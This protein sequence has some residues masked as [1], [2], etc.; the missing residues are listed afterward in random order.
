MSSRRSGRRAISLLVAATIVLTGWAGLGAS[1][2]AVAQPVVRATGTSIAVTATAGFQF[3][4]PEI[5]NVPLN[6]TIN[7]TFSDTDSGGLAHTFT[8]LNRSDWQI[9]SSADVAALMTDNGSLI[10]LNASYQ[11]TVQGNFHSPTAPGWYEFVCMASGH[12]QS[13][14]YGF[15]AFGEPV[16]TN[17]SLAS[18][19]PPAGLAVFIIVGTIVGLTVIALVLGFV[20]GRRHGDMHEMPPERLGYPEPPVAPPPATGP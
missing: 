16:P 14:M 9:P 3:E 11:Q 4:T 13:G 15:I 6:S 12:F 1:H 7:V 10:W 2:I 20:V 19:L 18:G 17:L 8:I 5:P